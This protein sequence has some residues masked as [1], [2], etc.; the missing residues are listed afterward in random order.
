MA[1]K[2]FATALVV[3][4]V[5]LP[6]PSRAFSEGYPQWQRWSAATRQG[7]TMGALN[8]LLSVRGIGAEGLWW[9]AGAS[10]CLLR[11]DLT[12]AV[13]EQQVTDA[14]R[15]NPDLW[16]VPAA[17]MVEYVVVRMCEAEINSALRSEP[18]LRPASTTETLENLRRWARTRS[19]LEAHQRQQSARRR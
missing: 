13:Y 3:A 2:S 15:A 7:Y 1:S 14:Y 19:E 17:K 9:T 16:T 10:V 6:M 4:S 11:L 18:G 8:Q 12:A 5:L